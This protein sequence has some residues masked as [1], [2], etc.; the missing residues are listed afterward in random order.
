MGKTAA[1]GAGAILRYHGGELRRLQEGITI[2]NAICFDGPRKLA[3]FTD[4][5]VGTIW[6]QKL[7][8]ETGWPVG[9]REDFLPLKAAGF[10]TQANSFIASE[11]T[12]ISASVTADA[13]VWGSHNLT[14]AVNSLQGWF[15]DRWTWLDT[16]W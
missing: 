2:P 1:A 12:F 13:T 5:R 16:Q 10:K 7:D 11:K 4:T 6:R 3:Y 14:G 9:E 15:D 8:P